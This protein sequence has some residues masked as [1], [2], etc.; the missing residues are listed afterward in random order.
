MIFCFLCFA[1]VTSQ[2]ADW[3]RTFFQTKLKDL[4][5][6]PVISSV[7]FDAKSLEGKWILVDVWASWCE[8]CRESFP[9]YEKIYQENKERGFLVLGLA[10]DN[11]KSDSLKFLSQSK[12][13]FPI[14]Y[15]EG[16]KLRKKWKIPSLPISFWVNPQGEVIEVKKGFKDSDKK[17]ILLKLSSFLQNKGEKR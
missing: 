15:D 11:D 10:M 16:K 13:S 1:Q 5:D 4:K 8:P 7:T 17:L 3:Q 14:L 6:L 2:A 9:F 12:V